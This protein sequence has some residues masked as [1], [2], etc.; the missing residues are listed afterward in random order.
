MSA[1][2]RREKEAGRSSDTT[3]FLDRDR[4]L[5][6]SRSESNDFMGSKAVTQTG[7]DADTPAPIRRERGNRGGCRHFHS[8]AS[9]LR[10]SEG[11][12]NRSRGRCQARLGAG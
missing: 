1:A 6:G 7:R 5:R 2:A 10:D 4:E 9:E 11:G 12:P 8:P 3:H